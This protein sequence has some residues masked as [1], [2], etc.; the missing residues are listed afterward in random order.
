M[1]EAFGYPGVETDGAT[2]HIAGEGVKV[3]G[4][5]RTTELARLLENLS[6]LQA[7]AAIRFLWAENVSVYEIRKPDSR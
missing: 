2:C 3:V 4:R 6:H 1:V 7:R 5:F